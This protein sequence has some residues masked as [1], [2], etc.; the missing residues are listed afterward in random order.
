[1]FLLTLLAAGALFTGASDGAATGTI[2]AS[3]EATAKLLRVQS[4]AATGPGLPLGAIAIA[5]PIDPSEDVPVCADFGTGEAPL[6]APLFAGETIERIVRWRLTMVA[7]GHG[8]TINEAPG[9][10][11]FIDVNGRRKVQF[12]P[13]ATD[14]E[15]SAFDGAGVLC[16]VEILV[17]TSQGRRVP[18]TVMWRERQL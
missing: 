18:R 12:W 7:A 4:Q 2:T 6:S 16:G 5:Q 17:L 15:A 13:Y 10:S 3:A 14:P 11:P 8:V 9:F 1:M